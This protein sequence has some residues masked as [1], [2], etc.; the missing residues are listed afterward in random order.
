[1][2]HRLLLTPTPSSP[3]LDSAAHCQHHAVGAHRH[4]CAQRAIS[5]ASGHSNA[6]EQSC[7]A[8]VCQHLASHLRLSPP[9]AERE[10]AL[11]CS[12]L[13]CLCCS[14]APPCSCRRPSPLQAPVDSWSTRKHSSLSACPACTAPHRTA[15]HCT[16][17]HCTAQSVCVTAWLCFVGSHL[18]RA[19]IHSHHRIPTG[20]PALTVT[21]KTVACL[22]QAATNTTPHP[23]RPCVRAS[24]HLLPVASSHPSTSLHRRL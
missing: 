18:P 9:P 1:L 21:R 12:A 23:S 20:T 3:P 2:L 14:T 17:P 5:A 22:D 10:S 4:P 13:P 7:T 11:P 24:T 8:C 19:R 6:N 16:A 15:P